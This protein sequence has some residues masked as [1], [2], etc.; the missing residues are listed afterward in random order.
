MIL[1]IIQ[2]RMGSTRFPGKVL[3]EIS[4]R[5]MLW[6]LYER[7]TF[8]K[9]IDKV[10]IATADTESCKPIVQFAEQ[11]SI[12]YH[13]GSEQDLVDRLYQTASKFN[14][15]IIVRITGDCPL[16]DPRVVDRVIKH[17][18]DNRDRYDYVSNIIKPTY[19]D[20]LDVGIIPFAT[21]EG[22]W[23]GVKDPFWREWVASYIIEHPEIYRIGNV[24]NEKDLSYLRWTVDYEEDFIFVRHIY[25]KLYREKKNFSMEDILALLDREPWIG[26]LNSKYSRNKAYYEA[27]RE[28]KK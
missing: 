10:V 7:M 16:V 25:D 23:K 3:K 12:G 24:E 5:P 6:Y 21:L 14:G 1:G 20:G 15:D 4:G 13:A 2:A 27:K 8:S 19:P 17:Y 18:M 9:L 28:A 26:K 11:N 22:M